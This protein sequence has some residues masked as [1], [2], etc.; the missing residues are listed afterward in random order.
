MNKIIK[1]QVTK[2]F[3]QHQITLKRLVI[4]KELPTEK[5]EELLIE[6]FNKIP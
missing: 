5:I 1:L 6:A 4:L 3:K 2:C